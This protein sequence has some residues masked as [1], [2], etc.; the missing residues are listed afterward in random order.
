[1]DQLELMDDSMFNEEEYA[2]LQRI[3]S[4]AK[5]VMGEY[6]TLIPAED[7]SKLLEDV[8]KRTTLN[9]LE[10]TFRTAGS[11]PVQNSDLFSLM[12]ANIKRLFAMRRCFAP[13][14][15]K[16]NKAELD[17]VLKIFVDVYV[18]M[19]KNGWNKELVMRTWKKDEMKPFVEKK[20]LKGK[21][22]D[23][24]LSLE[25]VWDLFFEGLE[26]YLLGAM[27]KKLPADFDIQALRNV[28]NLNEV[29][30]TAVEYMTDPVKKS[31]QLFAFR[32]F[33]N[34]DWKGKGKFD[35]LFAAQQLMTSESMRSA[36][37]RNPEEYRTKIGYNR[38]RKSVTS[39]NLK[40]QDA[41][42]STV[43]DWVREDKKSELELFED[44]MRFKISNDCNRLSGKNMMRSLAVLY[45]FENFKYFAKDGAVLTPALASQ[46]MREL[47]ETVLQGR[48][49][50]SNSEK[51]SYLES[52]VPF[53]EVERTPGLLPVLLIG[54]LTKFSKF[55]NLF[56]NG[57]GSLFSYGDTA[58][59]AS[60]SLPGPGPDQEY[61]LMLKNAKFLADIFER[62]VKG[63]VV[64]VPA[65]FSKQYLMN[66]V[67]VGDVIMSTYGDEAVVD[68]NGESS[69]KRLKAYEPFI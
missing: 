13:K 11:Y 36:D 2:R 59:N 27:Q 8:V 28:F 39:K 45:L 63:E 19:I 51:Y 3:T 65:Q 15:E 23:S 60:E 68:T 54:C 46:I 12:S 10:N 44:K 31:E 57:D 40:P 52:F 17:T 69:P 16:T 42:L 62:R 14:L 38:G 47:K 20:V 53:A 48:V 25:E 34:E 9:G 5:E 61:M 4:N 49:S 21:D 33:M 66:S 18:E 37:V 22:F 30:L 41:D 32:K 7:L 50:K 26:K 64:D 67:K 29:V 24:A 58:N 35:Q 1:M 6:R 55:Q 56:R 43:I